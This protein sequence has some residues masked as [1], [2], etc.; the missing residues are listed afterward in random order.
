MCSF[1]LPPLLGNENFPGW[2]I[3]KPSG[4]EQQVLKMGATLKKNRG[5]TGGNK[6]DR[7]IPTLPRLTLQ[8]KPQP[9]W[10]QSSPGFQVHSE[11]HLPQ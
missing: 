3:K 8:D 11:T 7:L 10:G 4:K 9:R 2:Q 6:D 5:T 1:H